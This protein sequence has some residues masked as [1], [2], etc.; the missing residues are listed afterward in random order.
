MDPQ[1]PLL[2]A[3]RDALGLKGTKYGCGVGICGICTVLLDGQANHACM[4]PVREAAEHTIT[5]IEGLAEQGH[6]LLHAWIAEQVPQCGY[7]QPGQLLA[8]AA[9]LND[10]PQ[11]TDAEID[12]AMG[13]VLCRCG[14][15][16][17]IRRA[18]HHAA[19][20]RGQPYQSVAATTPAE[21]APDSGVALNPWLRIHC[22]NTVTITINHS[23]LGQGV[24]TALAMLVAEELAVDLSHVRT[25]FAPAGEDYVNPLFGEQITGGSTAV[26]GQWKPLRQAGAR[27]RSQLVTA[28]ARHWQVPD[29]ECR[30]QQGS[31]THV[32][33]GRTLLY[34]E[35]ASQ[36]VQLN[37]PRHVQLTPPENWRLLGRP[38]PRLDIPAMITGQLVYGI[39]VQVS[40]M[41][42]ASIAR[43]PV[44]GGRVKRVDAAAALARPGVQA[45]EKI[46]SGVAVLAKD[47]YTAQRAREV[48]QIEWKTGS[49]VSLNTA[50]IH[51]Q[52]QEQS[53]H[54]GKLIHSEGNVQGAF[55]SASQCVEAAYRTSYLAHATLET[56]NC[57]AQVEAGRCDIWVGTQYQ[58]DSRDAAARITGLPK[59]NIHVHTQFSGGGFGRR[60]NV[61]MVAEAVQLAKAAAQP[62]QVIWEQRDDLQHDFYRP[63]HYTVLKAALDANGYPTAWWQHAVGPHLAL[64]MIDVPYAIANR[65]EEHTVVEAEVPTGAWR[66]VGAGQNAF[67]VESFI[68]ELAH[69]AGEDPW[70]YR[71]QL[72]A[73]APRHQ[74]VLDLAAEK[75]GWAQPLP[76]DHGRGIAIYQ[77]FGSWVAQ[78]AEVS[79]D[80]D[81]R[82]LVHKVVCSIDCGLAINPDTVR[83]QME[84]AIAMGLS[85]A[86]HEEILFENGCVQQ[87]TFTDYPILTIAEMPDVEI[88]I[89]NSSEPPGGVGEP[90]LPPIAP[91]LA[92]AVFAA[93]GQR[94]RNLPLRL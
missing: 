65:H 66:A 93:T 29:T 33:S 72:L 39:D 2:W 7:C 69:A 34:A 61:D 63:A 80:A 37:L 51:A 10:K 52:L 20:L 83:A 38:T 30:A 5:T 15:Y 35:L 74:A 85:A 26:R 50:S 77:S 64:E 91:A 46:E 89:V 54:Q 6:P 8:A 22:D 49:K 94:L 44:I 25:H 57:I 42:V 1:T 55:A 19:K 87:S 76:P 90:G 21:P 24:I 60:L 31:V 88:H 67:A 81:K 71:Q 62:V 84:G 18:I 47:F 70:R 53:K 23:E 12:T 36:A 16:S 43:C 75:A 13:G 9:L 32:P 78:V 86:L 92:N 27:A 3:L 45:V 82:I 4:V 58:T 73:H 11:P 68:D 28:A 79:V 17:R 59:G 41:L 40:N 48:L 56:M 14:T